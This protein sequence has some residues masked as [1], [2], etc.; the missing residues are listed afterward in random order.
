MKLKSNNN[1][2]QSTVTGK[3]IKMGF[4]ADA[5]NHLAELMSNSVYQDKYGS[6]VREVVSNAVDANVESGSTRKVEVSIVEKPAL[7]NGVAIWM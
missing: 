2:Y 4:A 7:S 1:Q 3:K 5:A 6:I